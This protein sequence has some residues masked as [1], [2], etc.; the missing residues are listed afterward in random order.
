M[1]SYKKKKIKKKK[2]TK[3]LPNCVLT[4]A[5]GIENIAHQGAN[6]CLFAIITLKKNRMAALI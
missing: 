2:K 3:W 4:I 6:K 1:T 5:F